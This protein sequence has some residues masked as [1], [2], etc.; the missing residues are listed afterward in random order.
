VSAR[1][2]TA[3]VSFGTRPNARAWVGKNLFGSAVDSLITV[4]LVAAALYALS[5]TLNWAILSATFTAGSAET[6]RLASGACWPVLIN[7]VNLLLFGTFPFDLR[8]RAAAALLIVFAG[9]ALLLIPTARRWRIALPAN[10]AAVAC[11]FALVG[12]APALG[13]RSV[14][15]DSAGGLLLT[16]LLVVASLPLALPLAV[17]LALGRRSDLPALRAVSTLYIEAVRALPMV[18]VLFLVSVMLPLLLQGGLNLPKVL[19]AMI[20]IAGFA[21]AYQAEVIRGGLQAIPR[22]QIEAAE[23]LGL[24]Y[25]AIQWKIVLPQALAIIVRPLS[26][27]YVTFLK[28]TSLVGVIGLFELTGIATMIITKPEWMGYS[29]EIYVTIGAVYYLMCAVIA[30]RA[31]TLERA[32]TKHRT[33]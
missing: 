11:A 19:R 1:Q 5:M 28:D 31:R 18:V 10:L 22:G 8:W 29:T 9:I 25:V 4:A 12:G 13:L 2:S 21:A 32:L 3:S 20:G 16:I 33:R 24:G 27:V 30:Q 6:C 23:A 14:D 17:L 15:L 26:G 7:N